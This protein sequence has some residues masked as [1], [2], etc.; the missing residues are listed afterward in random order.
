MIIYLDE[1]NGRR[2][3]DDACDR[4]RSGEF[5]KILL[6]ASELSLS[7]EDMFKVHALISQ[8]YNLAIDEGF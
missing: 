4:D 1:V 3:I 8:A 7:N 5:R 6:A 2:E